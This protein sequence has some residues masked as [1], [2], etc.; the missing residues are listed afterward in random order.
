MCL[1]LIPF[2]VVVSLLFAYFRPYKNNLFNIIDCLA[3]A[4]VALVN[5]LIMYAVRI[6]SFPVQLLYVMM[7]IPFMYFVFFILYK[8]FSQVVLFRTC[9]SRIVKTKNE[10][11]H[12]DIP[13]DDN[14]YENLP[15][16]MVNPD[17][18]RPLLP[19]TNSAVMNSQTDCQPQAGVNSLAAYGSM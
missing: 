6:K 15:D 14:I 7:L 16:R 5:Y 18:Y 4:L 8:I 12:L 17:M 3:F 19:A 10:N 2:S 1:I 11:Q 13:R 9:C